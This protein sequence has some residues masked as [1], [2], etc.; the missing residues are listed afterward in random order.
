MINKNQLEAEILAG[1]EEMFVKVWDQQTDPDR[2]ARIAADLAEQRIIAA[3][4]E[5]EAAR[6]TAN[7]NVADLVGTLELLAAERYLKA[8]DVGR[9]AFMGAIRG[10]LSI[11]I[12][13]AIIAAVGAA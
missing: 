9:D 11:L 13:T 4:A 1:L 7:G 5:T 8:Y 3:T 6:A 10:G 2:L 12:R